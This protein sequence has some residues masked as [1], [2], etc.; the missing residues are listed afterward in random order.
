MPWVLKPIARRYPR[1]EELRKG[2]INPDYIRELPANQAHCRFLMRLYYG[3]SPWLREFVNVNRLGRPAIKIWAYDH[4]CLDGWPIPLP[5]GSPCASS[6]KPD[7][8]QN[9][10]RPMGR[11]ISMGR[12]TGRPRELTR[13]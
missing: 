6:K 11:R 2:S 13:D 8:R 7:V 1:T 9:N 12:E 4:L 3:T 5:T 10:D